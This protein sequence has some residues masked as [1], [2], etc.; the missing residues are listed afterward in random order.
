MMRATL[1]V[2]SDNSDDKKESVNESIQSDSD[3]EMESN[4]EKLTCHH[5]EKDNSNIVYLL[6]CPKCSW[7]DFTRTKML[8]VKLVTKDRP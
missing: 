6:A 5:C 2:E 3:E 7:R 4:S 8:T 1:V